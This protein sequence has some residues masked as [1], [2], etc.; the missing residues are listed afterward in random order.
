MN[1][2]I[3]IF[4]I[5]LLKFIIYHIQMES[6]RGGGRG[7]G[8]RR[9]GRRHFRPGPYA[10]P[11]YAYTPY[12]GYGFGYNPYGYYRNFDPDYYDSTYYAY[13]QPPKYWIGKF[14]VRKGLGKPDNIADG[15]VIYENSISEPYQI[16]GPN[17][18]SGG[19]DLNRLL[20][21][22]NTS[23]FIENVRYG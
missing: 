22:I 9:G 7:G 8:W 19:Y 23:G 18:L 1:L 21:Y 14:L 12:Y 2:N 6:F 3:S 5:F 4:I 20:I 11:Y 10:R 16:V 13:K 17:E 15:D